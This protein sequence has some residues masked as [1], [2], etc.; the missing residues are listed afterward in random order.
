MNQKTTQ[1]PGASKRAV[2]SIGCKGHA[3]G[4]EHDMW[5][6]V[7]QLL[8]VGMVIPPSKK[9]NPFSGV[10]TPLRTWGDFPIPYMEKMGVWTPADMN[11]HEAWNTGWIW[12]V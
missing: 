9:G 12:L 5:H 7:P 10:Y 6:G 4:D 3:L 2:R 1:F 11:I 8:V